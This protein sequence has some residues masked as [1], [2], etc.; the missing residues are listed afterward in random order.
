[1]V[2]SVVIPRVKRYEG[3]GLS[4]SV[5]ECEN[6]LECELIGIRFPCSSNC[7]SGDVRRSTKKIGCSQ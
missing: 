7:L 1:M 3:K 4:G 5:R 6:I 2:A